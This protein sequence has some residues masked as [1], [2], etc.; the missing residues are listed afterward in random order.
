MAKRKAAAHLE[1]ATE[2]SQTIAE[3]VALHP[4]LHDGARYKRGEVIS[5]FSGDAEQLIAVGAVKPYTEPAE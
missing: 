5:L 3:Y 2:D 1:S 4:I